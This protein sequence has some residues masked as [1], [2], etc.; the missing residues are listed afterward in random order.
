MNEKTYD[1]HKILLDEEKD[2]NQFRNELQESYKNMEKEIEDLRSQI[3]K[4]NMNSPQ[5]KWIPSKTIKHKRA[6]SVIKGLK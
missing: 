2:L 4:S 6:N 5:Y 3:F 1:L